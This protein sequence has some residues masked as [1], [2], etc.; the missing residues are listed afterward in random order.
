MSETSE[1]MN[2]YF[3]FYHLL[4]LIHCDINQARYIGVI[5]KHYRT[6]SFL[7]DVFCFQMTKI[8]PPLNARLKTVHS[9]GLFKKHHLKEGRKIP[10][11]QLNS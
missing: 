9:L 6:L 2:S 1:V 8:V 11:E 3:L 7:W 4:N 5:L 10:E